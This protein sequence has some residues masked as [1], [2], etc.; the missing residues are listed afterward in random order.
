[1]KVQMNIAP[2]RGYS[3]DQVGDN[4]TTLGELM[5]RLQE[6]IDEHG[7]DAELV[8][9]DASNRYGASWGGWDNW[10]TMFEPVEGSEECE[11]CGEPDG[12]DP[13]CDFAA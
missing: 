2:H 1:M 7:E 5:A 9:F 11:V 12:H 10:G 4:A 3:A 8:T 6:A 13:E